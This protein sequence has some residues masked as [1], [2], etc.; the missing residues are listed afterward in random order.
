MA[1]KSLEFTYGCKY[2]KNKYGKQI[3]KLYEEHKEIT[4]KLLGLEGQVINLERREYVWKSLAK[5]LFKKLFN[6][7]KA[8]EDLTDEGGNFPPKRS[9]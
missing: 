9:R 1:K 2:I 6:D 5:D 8:I 7:E 3:Q 4:T